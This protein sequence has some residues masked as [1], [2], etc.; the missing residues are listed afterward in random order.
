VKRIRG[1][2][3][4]LR[5]LSLGLVL[6]LGL[7]IPAS[8][9][10]LEHPFLEDFG[11]ANEPTF[12]EA[13]GMAVD[14]STGDLLVIDAGNRAAG[15]GS[16]RRFHE[17]GTPSNF[18]A[19]GSNVIEGLTFNFPEEAQVAVDNSGG[20][21]EGDI[22]VPQAQAGIVKIYNADG[23]SV[24]QL[25]ES[26]EGPFNEPCGVGVDEDGNVY[27]SDFS[28]HVHRFASPP[29]DGESIDLVSGK[30]CTVAAGAGAT[31]G[32]IFPAHL[33]VEG[34]EVAKLNSTSGAQQYQVH[35]GPTTTVTVDP[36]TGHVLIASGNEVKEFD[37]SG[38]SEAL[39]LSPIAPG[40]EQVN[41]IAV[42]ET[43]GN[44]YV[45]RKGSPTIE[46][47][48]PAALLPEVTN[49][50]ASVIGGTVTLRGV[51]NAKEGP[52]ATCIFE[53][54]EVSAKGFE[55]ASTAPCSPAGPFTGATP[56][57]VSAEITGLPEASYRFRLVG[58]NESGSVGA[59]PPLL[60][61]TLERVPGLPDGRAYELVS[62]AQK[63]GQ[64]FPREPF[65]VFG[66]CSECLPGITIQMM[67]MQ[68]TPD[69]EAL[70]YEGQPF[71]AGLASGANEYLA[72]RGAGGWGTESLSG[73]AFQNIA[74]QGYAAFST[75]LSRGVIYQANPPLTPNAPG[76]GGLAFANLYLRAGGTL[77]PLILE[78]PPNRPPGTPGA[79]EN[80]PF[81]VRYAGA[82]AG[83][84]LSGAFTHIAFEAN[85]AL[86]GLT[87]VA[88]AAP[89]VEGDE[90][91][92][93]NGS[94]C[95]LYEWVN[96][97]LRLVNVLPGN[98]DAAGEAVIGAGRLLSPPVTSPI[99]FPNVERAVSAD[100]SRIFWSD[101]ESGHV[102]ARV[103]GTETLEVPGPALCK[104]SVPLA[105]RVCFQTASVDGS[106]VLL[107]NGQLDELNE[108]G[109]AYEPSA[110][111]TEGEGGFEGILGTSEDLSRIYFVDKAALSEEAN[112]NGEQAEEGKLNLYLWEEGETTFIGQL[113]GLDNDQGTSGRYGTWKPGAPGRL[114]QVSA[115]GRYM[116][117]VSHARLTGYDNRVSRGS[118]CADSGPTLNCNE[119]FAYDALKDTLSC[120]SCNPSGARPLGHSVLSVT[121]GSNAF[122]PFPQPGNLSRAGEGRLFFES[123][124]VL[125]PGDTNGE[126]QD[127][128][129]WE[130]NGV[131][132]CKRAAGCV[133]L[134]SGGRSENDS[135]FLESS[136][137][138][139]D[140]FFITR[141]QLVPADRN[142]QLDVYDAR[143]G[144][145]FP[146]AEAPFC[147]GD[148]CA[149]PSAIPPAQ[150]AAGSGEFSGAGNLTQRK[151]RCAKGKVRRRGRCVAKRRAPQQRKHRRRAGQDRRA[152]R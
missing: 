141:E 24:G 19:L 38:S 15:E 13:Q 134:I 89:E 23:S 150:P 37:A 34:G 124:D 80:D 22:Y 51:L 74:A 105:E 8:A 126:I 138:G 97:Q 1:R 33:N 60:F 3:P 69:G 56:V 87:G 63:I 135:M 99:E 36:G 65:S 40:G 149:G 86:S 26:S 140:A 113:V 41:G 11:A 70:L 90:D 94:S 101:Q 17:D 54:V 28:G 76:R 112:A 129:E 137:S 108:A 55:G 125:S 109:S 25:T 16:L 71:S 66:S 81:Q 148:A 27:V 79:E 72:R 106:R 43:T 123:K 144:G 88:P 45:A 35:P 104:E 119:V 58:E 59:K 136:H 64:V 7:L 131:G 32:F 121:K 110:D 96:G 75:D 100:G 29:V 114:S 68:S 12:T 146:E 20:S 49:E 107:S 46:V 145:G 92:A 50:P 31:D 14:Q 84:A 82:N 67:P 85:D 6:C 139:D 117:F 128:Y 77:T 57:A 10:A 102:Y 42:D 5:P 152:A 62:P 111:L 21:T 73:P 83:S 39:P 142:S 61:N 122:F 52:P 53:Y 118:N 120:A 44:V 4:S 103:G 95:N 78:E 130:P 147:E 91:C 132:G 133:Y 47:W 116:A 2:A 48:G 9:S 151:P 98:E 127:V 30:T 93:F 18:S 143:V 115:D